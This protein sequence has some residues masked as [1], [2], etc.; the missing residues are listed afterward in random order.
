VAREYMMYDFA[1]LPKRLKTAVVFATDA[2]LLPVA[3]WMSFALRLGPLDPSGGLAL[4]NP[5]DWVGFY[6]IAAVILGSV[7][8]LRLF[9]LHQI[10]LRAVD[11]DAVRR[12]AFCAASVGLYTALLSFFLRSGFP[13]SIP[14]LWQPRI[15]CC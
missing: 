12:M 9:R 5:L 7:G 15:S 1:T 2:L 14:V 4:V 13:R 3:L 11:L 10:Q 8:I 6:D